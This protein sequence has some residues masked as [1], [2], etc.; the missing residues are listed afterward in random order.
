M[1][2]SK[3]QD[4]LRQK[5]SEVTLQSESQGHFGGFVKMIVDNNPGCLEVFKKFDTDEE[6]VF[7]CSNLNRIDHM[8]VKPIFKPKNQS[9]PLILIPITN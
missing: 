2:R 1:L 9:N 6:R 8:I 5:C 7:Y 3:N 4:D